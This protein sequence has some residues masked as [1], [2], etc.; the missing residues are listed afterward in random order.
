MS[1]FYLIYLS[2]DPS[3]INDFF[4]IICYFLQKM[5][6]ALMSVTI[7]RKLYL[8]ARFFLFFFLMLLVQ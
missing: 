8:I 3:K 1:T 4:F 2:K 6:N 7:L 5:R